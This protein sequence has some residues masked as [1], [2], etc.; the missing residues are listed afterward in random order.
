MSKKNRLIVLL[1]VAALCSQNLCAQPRVMGVE[2]MFRLAD[3]NSRSVQVYATGKEAASEALKA[4]RNQRLPDITASV[5]GSY[6]GNGKLWDRDFGNAMKIDMPHWGN[7]F[8]LEVQQMIY[9]GG[10]VNSGIELASLGK[11]QAELGWEKNLE[12]ARQVIADMQA[13]CGQGTVLRN[14]I[15]RYEFQQES[16]KLQLARVTDACKI[17]NHRLVTALHLPEQTLV[18]PDSALLEA[19][20]QALAE[21][22]WQ[23]LAMRSNITLKQTETDIEVNKQLAKRE[24]SERLPKISLFAAEHLDGPIT[25]EVPVLDNNFNYWYVGVNVSYNF[26]ALFK[27]ARK[28]KQAKLNVRRA[29]E[30]HELAQEQV[31]NTVQAS[32]TDFL[33]AFTELKTQEKNV[34]LANENYSVTSNR[35]RN[36]LALLTDMLDAGN[37]KL[38]ADI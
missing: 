36:D 32:Y 27:N 8:S 31:E 7:N 12:L 10:A 9:T 38:S 33:T 6:W 4:A 24:R 3:E 19:E 25:I 13:R 34:Q 26:S 11:R 20:V 23:E 2:E 17:M 16:L 21:S 30:T 35:Y 14:D 15:T 29:Q 5:S 37:T 18:V 1:Y 22:D 28:L